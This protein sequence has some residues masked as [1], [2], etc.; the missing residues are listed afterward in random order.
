MTDRDTNA[1]DRYGDIRDD[2]RAVLEND[3]RS[4]VKPNTKSEA[5]GDARSAIGNNAR[6]TD[7]HPTGPEGNDGQRSRDDDRRPDELRISRR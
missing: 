4:D 1:G 7:S 6:G 2:E 3:T 5:R